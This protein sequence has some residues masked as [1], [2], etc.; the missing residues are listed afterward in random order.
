MAVPPGTT[1]TADGAAESVKVSGP[2]TVK[3]IVALLVR[4]PEVPETVTVHVPGA[5]TDE[6]ASV[7]ALA[8]EVDTVLKDPVTPFGKPETAKFTVPLNPFAGLTVIALVLLDPLARL[9]LEGAAARVKPGSAAT[10]NISL[11]VPV[12]LPAA[13]STV[14]VEVPAA[15]E[16]LAVSVSVLAVAAVAGLNDEVTPEGKPDVAK[17]TFSLKP[18]CALIE[19]V[20]LPLAP[21]ANDKEVAEVARL[22]PGG[23]DSPVKS[24]MSAWPAGL[25]QPVARS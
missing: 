16:P 3:L 14:M 7:S 8:L 5:A 9:T 19:I 25:P 24:S 23:F 4:L 15:A 12:R 6:A 2:V 22:N 10:V 13:P 21:G 18:F 17:L 1:F 20:L 11:V